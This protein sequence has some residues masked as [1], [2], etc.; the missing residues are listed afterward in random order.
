MARASSIMLDLMNA[1]SNPNMGPN[2]CGD[3]VS[4]TSAW[5]KKFRKTRSGI[6]I[7]A[8]VSVNTLVTSY[9]GQL[10]RSGDS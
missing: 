8:G 10:R 5:Q 1:P 3:A 2:N 6:C 4:V 9:G 7:P